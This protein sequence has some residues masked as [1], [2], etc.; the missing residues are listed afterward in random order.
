VLALL[1]LALAP[2]ALDQRYAPVPATVVPVEMHASCTPEASADVDRGA[3]WLLLLAPRDARRAFDR[4]AEADPD[5]ALAYWGLAASYL[6]LD[7]ETPPPSA[8]KAGGAAL[9]RARAVP[10]RAAHEQA[11]VSAIVPVFL[12]AAQGDGFMPALPARLRQYRERVCA[13]RATP[14]K[15]AMTVFCAR[16]T[17]AGSTLPGDAAGIDATRLVMEAFD[18]SA[19]TAGGALVVMQAEA[20]PP[21]VLL[22]AARA[23]V[24]LSPPAAAPFHL[25]SRTFVRAGDW[26]AAAT[27]GEAALA[28]AASPVS[29]DLVLGRQTMTA[30][31]WLLEAYAQQG[32]T[33][34]ARR[35]LASVDAA[36]ATG[37]PAAEGESIED[38]DVH[39]QA[40]ARMWARWMLLPRE[41]A[42]ALPLPQTIATSPKSWPI[43]FAGGLRAALDA[44]PAGR[45]D[46]VAEAHEAMRILADHASGDREAELGRVLIEAALAASQDEHQTL[47]L[48]V[49]HAADLESRLGRTRRGV[50]AL[51]PARELAG[52][53]WLRSYRYTDA[54]RESRAALADY[55]N[56]IG[57]WLVAA[58]A[59]VQIGNQGEAALA[60]STIIELRKNADPADTAAEEARRYLASRP[61]RGAA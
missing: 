46:L 56:R 42:P 15:P 34:D 44:W 54:I 29:P 17:L 16:A 51:V 37:S 50:R 19:L 59:A 21:A 4:A 60:Y 49:A 36:L 23:I 53:L 27:A 13:M 38:A 18:E 1:A 10:R 8:M 41:Y 57:P 52:A 32:R 3:A 28:R 35:L 39:R 43:V 11:L 25:A 20:A 30:G 2:D 12:P 7:D 48:L 61:E 33:G 5:C 31:E 9:R 40:L 26:A 24:R 47:D 6:P 22:S 14:A 58:R 45:P 55:P